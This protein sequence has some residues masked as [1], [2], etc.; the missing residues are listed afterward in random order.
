MYISDYVLFIYFV[1]KSAQLI[2]YLYKSYPERTTY[3]EAILTTVYINM[4][5]NFRLIYNQLCSPM[6]LKIRL[7]G[8]K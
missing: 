1:G 4:N 3:L 6:N 8:V 7:F 5:N 2:I